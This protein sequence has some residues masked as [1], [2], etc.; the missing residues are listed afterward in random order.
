MLLNA[1]TGGEQLV[2]ER[3]I[4]IVLDGLRG[5]QLSSL[6]G[7]PMEVGDLWLWPPPVSPHRQRAGTDSLVN[8]RGGR[9]D[10]SAGSVRRGR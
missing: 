4:A 3:A 8:V 2:R 9:A 1:P 7:H 10:G 5:Q 6:P